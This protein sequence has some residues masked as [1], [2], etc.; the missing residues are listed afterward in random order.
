[1]LHP[2][3]SA[4]VRAKQ[5]LQ[6]H[7]HDYHAQ[8][9][10]FEPDDLVFAKSYRQGTPWL[11]GVIVAKRSTTSFLFQ[12]TEGSV[13]RRHPDQL[14]HRSAEVLEAVSDNS[15]DIL[16]WPDIS[17]ANDSVTSSTDNQRTVVRHSNHTRRPPDRFLPDT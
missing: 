17:P 8:D 16:T 11:P 12:L 14:K 3:L 9:R 10:A 6:K 5:N 1:M 4:K 15:N 2:D 13:I 7:T